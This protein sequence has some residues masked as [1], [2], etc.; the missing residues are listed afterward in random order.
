MFAAGPADASSPQKPLT[1]SL[2][3]LAGIE[4]ATFAAT[5]HVQP[6]AANRF[7]RVAI[8]SDDWYRSSDMQLDGVS[9]PKRHTVMWPG[10]R[11]GRYCVTVVVFRGNGEPLVV[12]SRYTVL[13]DAGE[14]M[15][16]PYADDP[17]RLEIM[18]CL[19]SPDALS[20]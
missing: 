19:P 16:P 9:A 5:I 10:L 14:S 1:L 20:K 12:T 8:D 6:D 13:S 7:L 2:R 4:P 18:A 15:F 11:A 17:M 3:S